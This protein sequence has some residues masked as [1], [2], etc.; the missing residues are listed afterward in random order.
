[1]KEIISEVISAKMAKT[2]TVTFKRFYRYPL[3]GKIVARKSK[4][5]VRN[6]IG[7]MVGDQVAIIP[8]RPYAKTV[9]FTIVRVVAKGKTSGN[10]QIVKVDSKASK[11][12]V[13]RVSKKQKNKKQ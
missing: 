11:T 1:M 5:H 8:C 9:A 6:D 3:Y 12:Q 10:K 2:A 13:K 4:I 7:A